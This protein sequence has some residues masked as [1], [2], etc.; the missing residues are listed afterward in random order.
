MLKRYHGRDFVHSQA[1][2][3]P[4]I[5]FEGCEVTTGPLGQGIANSVGLAIASKHFA[6][7]YNRP[8]YEVVNNK[9]WCFS[10][11]G[12]LQE[13]VGQEALSLA[14]H[15]RLDNLILI[16]DDNSVTVDGNI[17][18]TF[19]EKTCAK[20]TAYGWHVIDVPTDITNDTSKVM[21]TLEQARLASSTVRKPIFIRFQ[22]SIGFGSKNAG[23][24]PTH[25]AALGDDDVAAVK[26]AHGVDPTQKYV[27]PD[28]VYEAFSGSRKHGE[29]LEA[30]WQSVFDQWTQ[31]HPDL[32]ED[33]RKRFGSAKAGALGLASSVESLLPPKSQLPTEAIPTRKASGIVIKALGPNVPQ[34]FAGS[35]DLM[36]STFVN[37]A[38]QKDLQAPE[39]GYGDYD[40]RQIRYGIRE[41]AMAAVANGMSAY[42]PQA[43][44]PVI[45]TFFM[46][47]LYAA[48]AIRMAALQKL[49]MVGI[50][51]HD[52][53]GIGED[54]PTHQ[55]IGL[56]SLF[57]S[58]P[59]TLLIRPAD[60]EEVMGAWQVATSASASSSPSILSLTRQGVPLLPGSDR[61]GVAKGAYTVH[62]A[63]SESSQPSLI[64]VATGSEVSLAVTVAD[65]L[66]AASKSS[67][68]VVSMPCQAL[69]DA[70]PESYR[71][72]VLP[73]RS[74]ALIVAIEVWSSYGWARYAHAS[75]SMHS[76]GL[77]GP[78][79]DLF[80]H[81]G[82]SADNLVQKIGAY[83]ERRSG[84][85]APAV[86][87][88]EELLLETAEGR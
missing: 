76:F 63:G 70:Q 41:H 69:F 3:H 38:G 82:F 24:C 79:A 32:S 45:S 42:H 81:F 27:I 64:L 62:V 19:T 46:F 83:V 58:I 13:G 15:M 17:D 40:G 80:N 54:G 48:P 9:I 14:G 68:R 88:F 56:A 26:Q 18:L 30:E 23:L 72:T 43:I 35:A 5:E 12:C 74:G 10:G 20:L 21:E 44:L 11:D 28:D 52:S 57:R 51:T 34:L 36:E 29:T 37:W 60:A 55:P 87:E 75:V 61:A 7:T 53:I 1:A 16:Y 31:A 2:G 85:P 49:R 33:F 65:K 86:G 59:N 71:Q 73:S 78:Q 8:G 47:F 84:K 39:T 6:A 22:T 77:S 4:E 50:A 25:G 67:V 66:S